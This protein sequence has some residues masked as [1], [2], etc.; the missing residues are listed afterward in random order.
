MR[1]S[2]FSTILLAL[3]VVAIGVS[4]L[5]QT[6]DITLARRAPITCP[7]TGAIYPYYSVTDQLWHCSTTQPVVFNGVSLT[8]SAAELNITDGVT[9]TAAEINLIDNSVA[10][11]SVASKALSLDAN[12]AT[13]I[14]RAKS[15]LSV[16]GTAVPGAASVMTS[17]TKAV[18]AFTDTT[19]KA[20][21][22]VTV[23]NAAHAAVIEVDVLGVLGAGGAI[24]AGEGSRISKY[25]VVLARTAGVN[26]VATASS[27]MGGAEAHVAGAAS[28]SSVV[29]TVSSITGAVGASN[30]FT[31]NVAITKS[32]GASDNH[33]LVGTARV[34]NQNATGVTIS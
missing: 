24:G 12:K 16:G 10:G 11:T 27:A 4:T 20:V 26:V 21:W 33:T 7:K 28:V 32:G 8:A 13:D 30:T 22:T 34:L 19:A 3:A 9:A 6:N 18:T 23:P 15:E 2:F 31:I 29:V 5:A 14:L 25:Q 1:R 17:V